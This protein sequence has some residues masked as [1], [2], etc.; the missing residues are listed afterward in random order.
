MP[1]KAAR[2]PG[3]GDTAGSTGEGAGDEDDE[4]CRTSPAMPLPPGIGLPP[5][6][7][8]VAARSLRSTAVASSRFRLRVSGLIGRAA[9]TET[10]ASGAPGAKNVASLR[11]RSARILFVASYLRSA[12]TSSTQPSDAPAAFNE[13]QAAAEALGRPETSTMRAASGQE[14]RSSGAPSS[15]QIRKSMSRVS[16]PGKRGRR[17]ISSASTQPAAQRSTDWSPRASKSSSGG[18]Y[19]RVPT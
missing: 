18:R 6:T 11:A 19:Q 8:L 15:P 9:G 2:A 13:P 3:R 7:P 12:A 16:V 14:W 4:A 17:N 10:G 1:G 5:G